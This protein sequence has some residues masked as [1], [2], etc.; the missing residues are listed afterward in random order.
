VDFGLSVICNPQYAASGVICKDMVGTIGYMAPE[1][2]QRLCYSAESD[3]WSAGV[4]LYCVLTGI[5]PFNSEDKHISHRIVHGEYYP[6]N[7]TYW[8]GISESAKDLV[9]KMLTVD[10]NKRITANGILSHPWITHFTTVAVH[11]EDLGQQYVKRI[12][13]LSSRQKFR[14]VV[15]GIIWANRLRKTHLTAILFPTDGSA[16]Q[17]TTA[18]A[19]DG[20][21]A[22]A[23]ATPRI[24]ALESK[25]VIHKS[26]SVLPS[27]HSLVEDSLP[28]KELFTDEQLSMLRKKFIDVARQSSVAVTSSAAK[29]SSLPSTRRSSRQVF[30]QDNE[31]DIEQGIGYEQFCKIVES[32]G[33]NILAQP[34]VFRLFDNDGNGV[35]DYKEFLMALTTFRGASNNDG[36]RLCFDIFDSDGSGEISLQEL[37][38]VMASVMSDADDEALA[39]ISQNSTAQPMDPDNVRPPMKVREENLE[40]LFQAIDT[41]GDGMVSFEEF[42]AWVGSDVSTLHAI[43]IDPMTKALTT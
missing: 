43:F 2:I 38:A 8:D 11:A 29:I 39:L 3:I 12:A 33:L 26:K 10:P 30:G 32:V 27:R 37:K 42:Q 21:V 35:V 18:P 41:N 17:T 40:A 34:H 4:I 20:M 28:A 25:A 9:R 36:V 24:Q 13:Q 14:K 5:P 16:A 23:P 7:T 22:S 19:T 1:S 6:M 15:N 31:P